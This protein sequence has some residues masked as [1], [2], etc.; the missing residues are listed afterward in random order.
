MSSSR[1]KV[2][3]DLLRSLHPIKDLSDDALA[4]I[5]DKC[6]VEEIPAGTVLFREGGNDTMAVYVLYGAV[7]LESSLGGNETLIGGS[8]KTLQPLAD[9]RPRPATATTQTEVT[10]LRV[11]VNLLNLLRSKDELPTYDVA[12]VSSEEIDLNNKLLFKILQDL[13]ADKLQL[14]MLPDIA[15]KV[16]EAVADPSASGQGVAKILQSDPTIAARVIQVANSVRFSGQM[17]TDNLAQAV[18]RVGLSNVRE[19]VMALTMRNIFQSKEAS[20]RKRLFENW[21]HCSQVAATA[22]VL[23]RQTKGFSA[24]RALLAGLVHQIGVVPIVKE[25]ERHAELMHF[26]QVLED[27]I[28]QL[29]GQIGNTLLLRWNFPDDIAAV[30]MESDNWYR[31]SGPKPD[32]ADLILVSKLQTYAGTSRMNDFPRLN[33]VPAA[34]K[35]KLGDITEEHGSSVLYELRDKIEQEQQ[36]L[37]G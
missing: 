35:F 6:Y 8:N 1:A 3:L 18:M 21:L 10:L 13:M 27:T 17:K 25:A 12:E 34:A 31:D 26:P 30:T 11:S 7:K 4:E 16:R 32:Y 5:A 36:V 33:E 29:A 14:P 20:L 28:S 24:D 23:A 19:L 2:D 37:V 9:K 22:T 15:I